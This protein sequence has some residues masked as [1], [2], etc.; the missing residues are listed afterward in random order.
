MKL[1]AEDRFWTKIVVVENCWAWTGAI[2][3]NGYGGFWDGKR[4]GRAPRVAYEMF[5]GPIPEG[6]ELDHLC[7]NRR[8]VNPW[9]LEAVTHAENIRR[10]ESPA[11]LRQSESCCPSG[12]P[13]SEHGGNRKDGKR[14]CRTCNRTRVYGFRSLYGRGRKP[15]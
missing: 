5:R 15:Q 2:T 6:R 8:C 4:Y 10:G 7:R 12:H 14:Y 13:Y 11:I 1:T 9:H 3:G